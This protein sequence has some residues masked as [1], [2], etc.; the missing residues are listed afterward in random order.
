MSGL[1]LD[2]MVAICKAPITA[3]TRR[4]LALAALE[5]AQAAIRE[6]DRTAA[7]MFLEDAAH[8]MR[9]AIKCSLD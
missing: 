9:E 3:Q 4:K 5:T 2:D 1:S 7:L 8:H 6:G